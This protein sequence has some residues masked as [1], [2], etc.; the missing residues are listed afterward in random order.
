MNDFQRQNFLRAF[1][2]ETAKLM[3]LHFGKPVDYTTIF[4][5]E[6]EMVV[7]GSVPTE[8]QSKM[9][10]AAFL[11]L[12]NDNLE[13]ITDDQLTPIKEDPLQ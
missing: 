5:L 9:M 6:G 4:N 1:R 3:D 12:N 10:A 13:L 2:K 7:I 8:I 11:A